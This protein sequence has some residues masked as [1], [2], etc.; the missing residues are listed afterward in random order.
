M[1]VG[2]LWSWYSAYITDVR[3]GRSI[4]PGVYGAAWREIAD[5]LPRPDAILMVSAHWEESP[6]TIGATRPVPL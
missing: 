4:E 2:R 1:R 6:L 5:S 3:E